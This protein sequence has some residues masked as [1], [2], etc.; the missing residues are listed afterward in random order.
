[1]GR[2]VITSK[3]IARFVDVIVTQSGS[4]M[5]KIELSRGRFIYPNQPNTRLVLRQVCD[6]SQERLWEQMMDENRQ[7]VVEVMRLHSDRIARFVDVVLDK[8]NIS[9]RVEL[10]SGDVY[11]SCFA[12]VKMSHLRLDKEAQGRLLRQLEAETEH[13]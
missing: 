4:V 8:G 9:F 11:P 12:S 3:Q 1:M 5:F 2:T 7:E 10:L 13:A 6:E